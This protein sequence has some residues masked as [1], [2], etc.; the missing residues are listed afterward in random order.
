MNKK[1]DLLFGFAVIAMA[2]IFTLTGCPWNGKTLS[3]ISITTQPTKTI[4][5]MGETLATAGLVVTAKYS[6]YSSAEVTSFI[7][8]PA[9]GAKLNAKGSPTV[10]V[11]YTEGGVTETAAFTVTV[12][13]PVTKETF[14]DNWKITMP[15]YKLLISAT[16]LTLKREDTTHTADLLNF[17]ITSWGDIIPAIGNYV[18][19][20]VKI[21]GTAPASTDVFHDKTELYLAINRDS[22][23]LMIGNTPPPVNRGNWFLN[24]SSNDFARFYRVKE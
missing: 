9:D 10:T 1:Q 12:K 6:D 11:S 5:A 21:T 18:D 2:A 8:D 24:V 3:S 16:T 17:A 15:N 7:T 22:D 4:Y 14:Q 23:W 20:Y 19:Y 13:D